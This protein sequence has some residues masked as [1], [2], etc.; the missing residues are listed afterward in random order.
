[1]YKSNFKIAFYFILITILTP[2]LFAGEGKLV[3]IEGKIKSFTDKTIRVST[4]TG[5]VSIPRSTLPAEITLKP[6]E[7]V[8]IPVLESQITK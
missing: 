3:V 2:L 4:A 5:V 6:D 7:Q 8:K 1:M